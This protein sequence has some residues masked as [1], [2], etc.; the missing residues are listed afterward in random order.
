MKQNVFNKFKANKLL[1]L[2]VICWIISVLMVPLNFALPHM[3]IP[4]Q[5]FNPDTLSGRI[6]IMWSI[7]IMLMAIVCNMTAYFAISAVNLKSEESKSSKTLSIVSGIVMFVFNVIFIFIL[8]N[9]FN[10]QF[11]YIEKFGSAL[12]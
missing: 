11:Y 6:D 3:F 9:S 2:N 4:S 12:F 1:S 5:P 10:G 7:V 8:L